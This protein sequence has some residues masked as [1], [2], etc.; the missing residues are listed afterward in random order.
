MAAPICPQPP[1]SQEFKVVKCPMGQKKVNKEITPS[2]TS[3]VNKSDDESNVAAPYSTGQKKVD[4]EVISLQSSDT[5]SGS[6]DLDDY[7]DNVS[8]KKWKAKS[9]GTLQASKRV[10]PSVAPVEK[11]VPAKKMKGKVLARP[12]A[13]VS[14]RRA[15]SETAESSGD[16]HI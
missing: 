16:E 4:K 8:S 2:A 10:S 5:V 15:T 13:K 11:T 14:E 9:K 7:Q 1:P 3:L 6:E 12:K